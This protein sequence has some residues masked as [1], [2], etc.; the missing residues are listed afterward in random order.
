MRSK[1]FF[2]IAPTTLLLIISQTFRLNFP[3][4]LAAS[5]VVAQTSDV[6]KTEADQ[7][8]QQG[9]QQAQAPFDCKYV[10]RIITIISL[11]KDALK[12]IYGLSPEL[13]DQ[14][15]AKA[16]VNFEACD[17]NGLKTEAD[18]LLQQGLQEEQTHLFEP[19]IKSLQQAL[20][21]YLAIQEKKSEK[22]ALINLGNVYLT[23]GNYA[24]AVVC[25]ERALAN[26]QEMND[27]QG[28]KLVRQRL[29]EIQRLIKIRNLE[30]EMKAENL[31]KQGIQQ[32]Q[33]RQFKTAFQSLSQAYLI[34]EQIEDEGRLNLR[35][36][37]NLE[38]TKF[39]GACRE[40]LL[41]EAKRLDEQGIQQYQT[42]HFEV[43]FQSWQQALTIYQ[44]L[45]VNEAELLEKLGVAYDFLG[46]YQQA[47]QFYRQ[48]LKIYQSKRIS[49]HIDKEEA[50]SLHYLG[51]ALLKSGK[52]E[53]AEYFLRQNVQLL[54][55]SR[56]Y[57]QV[58]MIA[59][60]SDEELA[61]F[62]DKEQYRTYPVLQQALIAQNKDKAALE[63]SEQGRTRIFSDSL[64]RSLKPEPVYR[65]PLF[66]TLPSEIMPLISQLAGEPKTPT[67]DLLSIQKIQQIAK[68]E[69]AT[70]VEYSI[71]SSGLYIWV[72]KPSGEIVFRQA[73]LTSLNIPL[74]DLVTETRDFMGISRSIFSA[75]IVNPIDAGNPTKRLQQLY[76]LLIAPIAD[77]LPTDQSQRVIFVPQSELFLV[78]FAALQDDKGKYLIEK[79]TILTAPSIQ[80]L[81]LTR[82]Q[83]EKVKQA[84]VKEAIVVGNPTMPSVSLKIGDKPRQLT[85]LPGAKRE[86]ETIAPLLNTKALTGDEA[87][88][89]TVLAR[90]PRARIVHLATH[91]LFDDFQ[92]LQSAVALAPTSS[93]NGLLTA[94]DILNLKLNA[95]LVVLSA[96]NTGR[97]RITGDGVIGLSR[98]LFIAGTPSVIV[99]LWSVPD[100]PTAELMTDFYTNLYQKKLD[101]AQALRMAMLKIM[102]KH[103]DN[104]RAWAAFTL[105]GEAE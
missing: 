28:E 14:Q 13:L 23:Q 27:Y 79:H 11:T 76:Q 50:I 12:K 51:L 66:Y 30:S 16:M 42:G 15:L 92:G 61:S 39:L 71:V 98:S 48:Q 105:I 75:A 55:E 63:I 57:G 73:N 104:P 67:A 5:P 82:Q 47:I 65:G 97:G 45:T 68:V 49:A 54:E 102:E 40:A 88:K 103:R 37:S 19:A 36:I 10:S 18:Q 33:L 26:A 2:G 78:P 69:K 90:L 56:H 84:A 3:M 43:A 85:S 21:I 96:C 95:D 101:K 29:T 17:R 41:A 44:Q 64:S 38:V 22:K 100:A 99:S 20:A 89:A 31:L 93:D 81:D 58:Y 6:R 52:P 8:F 72:I 70:L 77:L 80:V 86:A 87:T 91:G 1:R 53:E 62:F 35:P 60:F 4:P 94:E 9:F 25:F 32:Y 59:E 83:A 74:K 24:A 34:Y 46:K 7:L